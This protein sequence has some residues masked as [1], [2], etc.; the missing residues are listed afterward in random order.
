MKDILFSSKFSNSLCTP[1][2]RRADE[3]NKLIFNSVYEEAAKP[4]GKPTFSP[5][6]SLYGTNNS[7]M[8][9]DDQRPKETVNPRFFFRVNSPSQTNVLVP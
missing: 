4:R 7:L 3:A 6:L 5:K 8:Q 1:S 2:S 9:K